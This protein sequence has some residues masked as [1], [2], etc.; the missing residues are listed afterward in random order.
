VDRGSGTAFLKNIIGLYKSRDAF[1]LA[2][3]PE[4]TRA[5]AK[6][7]K[8]GFYMIAENAGVPIGLGYIDYS[9]KSVGIGGLLEPSGDIEKDFEIIREFYSD[10]TG[11]VRENQGEIRLKKGRIKKD[12]D[13]E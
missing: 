12:A 1:I 7:W 5:K 10:K 8:T 2:I 6:Y 4:G 11:K 13:N 3:A 9:R